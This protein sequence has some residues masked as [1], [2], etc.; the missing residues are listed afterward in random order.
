LKI[1]LTGS[2]NGLGQQLHQLLIAAGHDVVAPTRDH[3][4]LSVI[5]AVAAFAPD[6]V[7]MLINCAGTGIGGKIDFCQHRI[8]DV[9]EILNTNFMAPV[10]LCHTV[11]NAN[12]A[13]KIVNITSTNNNRYWPNDLAY[14][15]SKKAL[16]DLGNML[17]IEYPALNYLEVRLGLTK[18]NFNQSRYKNDPERFSDLYE[19][20]V[21]Q[22]ANNAANRIY[23]VLFDS[24]IKFIEIAP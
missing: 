2:S 1:L 7:D 23:A 18:T 8:D 13:C 15:L 16:E 22:T 17:R 20:N 24:N 10:V 12:P 3:L 14:S 6:S 4:D 21:Y 19:T 9:V 5:S 11:L